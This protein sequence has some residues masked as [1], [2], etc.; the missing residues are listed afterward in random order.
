M[1]NKL[2]IVFRAAVD[3]VFATT[4]GYRL[5]DIIETGNSLA[6]PPMFIVHT[7]ASCGWG[8]QEIR[9]LTEAEGMI[10]RGHRV[11]IWRPRVP[12]YL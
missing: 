11:E 10:E 1:R 2:S 9:I 12:I 7:E 6:G 5:V 4:L 8:G 3:A